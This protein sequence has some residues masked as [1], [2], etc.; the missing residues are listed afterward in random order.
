MKTTPVLAWSSLILGVA[1]A[2]P[3]AAINCENGFQRVK[4]ELIATPYCQDQYLAIVAH[5]YGFKASQQKIRN[6]PNYK[7]ELCRFVFNDVRVQGTCLDAGVPELNGGG[8]R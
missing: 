5:Q 1:F 8:V 2:T 6:D 4:G 7:K 3:A